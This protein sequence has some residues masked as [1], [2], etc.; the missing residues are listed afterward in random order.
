MSTLTKIFVVLVTVFSIAFTMSTISFVAR[1]NDW[2]ALAEAYRAERNIVE[3]NMVSQSAAHA[4]EKASWLDAR[5]G[6]LRQVASLEADL[7]VLRQELQEASGGLGRVELEK[8]EATA[9]A[10]GLR[11]LL[12]VES[13][14]RNA[15]ESQR[16]FFQERN[17]E[18]E[19][20]NLDLK[21]RVDELSAQKL[22]LVEQQRQFEQ[23]INI[24][25]EEKR[26]LSSGSRRA[27]VGQFEVGGAD[28]VIPVEPVAATPIRGRL[29]K[30]DGDLAMVSVGSADGVQENMTFVIYRGQEYV[31]DLRITD[32][33]PDRSAGKIVRSRSTP[34]V[35]D[36]VA[37]EARFGMAG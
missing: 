1:T 33:E 14:H 18:L 3:T 13:E 4:A 23:Q 30:I 10:R 21:E 15:A 36:S 2:K 9:L 17:I 26:K 24:L 32:V 27:A 37:D 25:Q 11:G 20:R 8:K 31:G 34:R 6:H 35:D 16:K 22:V 12:Q 29:L 19:T 7:Q 28:E 5:K